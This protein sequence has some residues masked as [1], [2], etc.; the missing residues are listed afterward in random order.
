MRRFPI[1][2]L[3]A[4]A[5]AVFTLLLL[6][7]RESVMRPGPTPA[8]EQILDSSFERDGRP[9]LEGW[10]VTNPSLTSLVPEPAPGGGRWSLGLAA[11][12]APTTGFVTLPLPKI[13]DGD[14]LRLSAFVRAVDR[15]GGG[16]IGLAVLRVVGPGYVW[17]GAKWAST[18]STSWTRLVLQDTVSVPP[19]DTVW[20][21][22]SSHH[23]E[24]QRREGRFDLVTLKRIQVRD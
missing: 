14:V 4:C 20:V 15:E 3:P 2:V 19:G 21:V 8:E 16:S 1:R 11:D 24:I 6:S 22:L 10:R 17:G 9:T 23:T 5:A 12:W 18:A 13:R 7:C